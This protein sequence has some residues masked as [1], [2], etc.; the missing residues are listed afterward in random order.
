MVAAARPAPLRVYVAATSA[1]GLSLVVLLAVRGGL[2]A[3][4]TAPTAYWLL[5]G[6]LLASELRPITVP[7]RD[8][9]YSFTISTTF[10]VALLLGWGL[11]AA[12]VAYA[13]ASV[14]GD[15]VHGRP[16]RAVAFNAAQYTLTL[17]T[18]AAAY[19]L[20]GGTVPFGASNRDLLAF[21]GAAVAFLLANNALVR[22]ASALSR[23]P[24]LFA[25]L[26]QDLRDD[27]HT[28]ALTSTIMFAVAPVTLMVATVRVALLLL[29]VIPLIGLYVLARTAVNAQAARL[30]AI[31]AA[32][33]AEA[34]E[35]EQ[36][37]LAAERQVLAEQNAEAAR[38]KSNLLA[39]ISHEFRTPLTAALGAVTTLVRQ[40]TRLP[41]GKHHELLVATEQATM[42]LDDLVRQALIAAECEERSAGSTPP[43][44]IDLVAE[45]RGVV[46]EWDGRHPDRKI[47]LVAD[48]GLR[49]PVELTPEALRRVLANLIDNAVKHAPQSPSILVEV[50]RGGGG[51]LVVVEDGGPGIPPGDRDRVFEWFTQ[52]DTSDTRPVGGL[53]LGL[54][55]A[56]QT[57]RTYGGDLEATD[58]VRS[59][60]G[61]RFELRLPTAPAT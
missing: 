60:R 20:I 33:A 38:L 48:A 37:R 31:R 3:A 25:G 28:Q 39:I 40:Q 53:G 5:V 13:L 16:P 12:V 19:D 34:N 59:D 6:L 58:P 18:A 41:A 15:L 17:A 51:A 42:R 49:L 21:L 22:L 14:V 36:R 35:A 10:A 61:A 50:R 9:S 52:L 46:D 1:A 27:F 7:N 26:R 44:P 32:E 2:H 4:A 47:T 29:F 54:Y 43:Q 8:G 57:A 11:G 55:V 56:R 23:G 30:A 45:A 24:D